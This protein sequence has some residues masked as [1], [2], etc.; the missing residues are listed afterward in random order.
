MDP[1]PTHSVRPWTP[2]ETEAPGSPESAYFS[3]PFRRASSCA[4]DMDEHRW[5][6]LQPRSGTPDRRSK[7]CD[8]PNE[9]LSKS[10]PK[11]L[12]TVTEPA[13]YTPTKTSSLLDHHAPGALR[14][15]YTPESSH[16]L[17]PS[18][19]GS[20]S[21]I[22]WDTGSR[23]SASPVQSAL[24]SCIAHFEN[25][26]AERELTDDQMEYIVGQFENMTSFLAAP[27]AQTKKGADDLFS[28]ADSPRPASP[29][30]TTHIAEDDSSYMAEVG[31]Y[32][33]GVQIYTADLK[34][35][36]EEAKALNEIQ[37]TIIDG[38]R[39][40]MNAMQQNMQDS[41]YF[42]PSNRRRASTPGPRNV[43]SSWGSIETAVDNVEE[44][45]NSK[46][47]PPKP[48]MVESST[49]TDERRTTVSTRKSLQPVRRGFWTVLYEALDEFSDDLHEP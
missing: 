47:A 18:T 41:L 20:L 37:L 15:P 32:I 38:L 27:D 36:F 22:P 49:Q 24:S 48:T 30:P 17:R 9:P 4:S 10:R 39:R 3:D 12:H 40:D 21:P 13:P 45:D 2:P 34:K 1:P 19:A 14:Y 35:R 6:L 28:G 33:E 8:T 43:D 31:K 46:A 23:S 25:L 11:P 26:T 44:A 42:S 7:R 5:P 29:K 16:I